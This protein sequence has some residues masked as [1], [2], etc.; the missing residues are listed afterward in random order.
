MKFI[1][2]RP[3]PGQFGADPRT[4]D[5]TPGGEFRSPAPAPWSARILRYAIVVAVLAAA[6]SIAAMVLWF[7]LILIPVAIGAALIAYAAFRYRMW[8]AGSSLRR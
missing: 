3:A 7:A 4:I 6:L 2:N 8:R 5:M 1:I